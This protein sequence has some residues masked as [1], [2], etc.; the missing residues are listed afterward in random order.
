MHSRGSLSCRVHAQSSGLATASS[1]KLQ[2][3]PDPLGIILL[4]KYI[5]RRMNGASDAGV[6]NKCDAGSSNSF[7]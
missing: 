2:M 3:A 5:R 4:Y 1:T 6:N 7:V